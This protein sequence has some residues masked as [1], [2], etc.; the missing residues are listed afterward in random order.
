MRWK[1]IGSTSVLRGQALR[2]VELIHPLPESTGIPLALS[3]MAPL[4]EH[5]RPLNRHPSYIQGSA[6]DQVRILAT[7]TRNPTQSGLSNKKEFVGLCN[8]VSSGFVGGLMRYSND[9]TKDWVPPAPCRPI[10]CCCPPLQAPSS[11]TPQLWAQCSQGWNE[12]VSDLPT[13]HHII[14]KKKGSFWWLSGRVR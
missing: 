10:Y 3:H 1:D 4:E 11:G 6:V 8:W 12:A 7:V 13:S 9:A 2:E 14:P 5:N